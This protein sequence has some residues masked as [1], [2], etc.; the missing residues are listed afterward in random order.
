MS[1]TVVREAVIMLELKGFVEV[2]KGSGIHVVSQ[3]SVNKEDKGDEIELFVRH[4]VE[5]L[6]GVGPFEMLQAR[7]LIECSIVGFA[8][9]QVTKADIDELNKIQQAGLQDNNR[10]DSEWDKTFHHKIGEITNNSV[11]SLIVELMWFGRDQNPL[12]LKLH[13]HIDENSLNTWDDEHKSIIQGFMMKSPHLAKEAMW[14][15]L[16]STK[17]ALYAASSVDDNH[18]DKYLFQDDPIKHTSN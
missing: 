11:L 16:E 6:K 3:L 10:R 5:E 12:W 15:H 2:K 14:N 13:E 8:A 18:Y 1:R 9:T 17:N 7:Q 4:M